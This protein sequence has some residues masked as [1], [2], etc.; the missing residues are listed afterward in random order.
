MKYRWCMRHHHRTHSQAFW[1]IC[2]LDKWVHL[3]ASWDCPS[4]PWFFPAVDVTCWHQLILPLLGRHW[5]YSHLR[6][7]LAWFRVMLEFAELSYWD[8]PRELFHLNT[9]SRIY[10]LF[11]LKMLLDEFFSKLSRDSS[12]WFPI[13]WL[14]C[15]PMA[16]IQYKDTVGISSEM[17]QAYRHLLRVNQ[18]LSPDACLDWGRCLHFRCLDLTPSI[19]VHS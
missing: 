11:H 18:A 5:R 13:H 15:W 12:Y 19:Q 6:H 10:L 1:L 16:D 9:E 17:S 2:S 8:Q 4:Y 7:S 14:W 3:K